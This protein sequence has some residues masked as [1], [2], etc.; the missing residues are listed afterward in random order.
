MGQETVKLQN[1]SRRESVQP[2]GALLIKMEMKMELTLRCQTPSTEIL[3]YAHGFVCSC[4]CAVSRVRRWNSSGTTE[5]L[6][7]GLPNSSNMRLALTVLKAWQVGHMENQVQFISLVQHMLLIIRHD[8]L[9]SLP[10][11]VTHSSLHMYTLRSM[12]AVS[13]QQIVQCPGKY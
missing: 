3:A 10:S 8:K 4:V 11:R 7:S 1:D 2:H 9:T 5:V 12:P 6:L 13:T